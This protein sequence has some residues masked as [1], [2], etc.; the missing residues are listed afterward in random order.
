MIKYKAFLYFS[1]ESVHMVDK[2][3][4]KSWRRNAG[5]DLRSSALYAEEKKKDFIL[6]KHSFLYTN[7]C[8]YLFTNRFLP[9]VPPLPVHILAIRQKVKKKERKK[10]HWWNQLAKSDYIRLKSGLAGT[11]GMRLVDHVTRFRKSAWE[12]FPLNNCLI[13]S[14]QWAVSLSLSLSLWNT[15]SLKKKN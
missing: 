2:K 7:M 3:A 14:E 12:I 5:S 13:W 4:K 1:K 10:A 15:Q 9:I 6:F 8:S 11:I